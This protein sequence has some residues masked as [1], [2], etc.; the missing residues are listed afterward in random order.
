MNYEISVAKWAKSIVSAVL[1]NYNVASEM[2]NEDKGTLFMDMQLD[3][4]TLSQ[5]SADLELFKIPSDIFVSDGQSISG[6]TV[7]YRTRFFGCDLTPSRDRVFLDGRGRQIKDLAELATI[8]ASTPVLHG[9]T[10]TKPSTQIITPAAFEAIQKTMP[11]MI[12]ASF[13]MANAF[14][15]FLDVQ[16]A[17]L[18]TSL[19][20]GFLRS[21]EEQHATSRMLKKQY[22]QA[23]QSYQE[24]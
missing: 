12:A 20:N 9:L 18:R 7:V 16:D 22:P 15:R 5:I 10:L 23:H 4:H 14:S 11:G 1:A 24:W 19:Y 21:D 2:S 3:E 6:Q 17:V 13:I 8:D